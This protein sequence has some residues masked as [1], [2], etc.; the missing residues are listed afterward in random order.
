MPNGFETTVKL[1]TEVDYS[2]IEKINPN[3]VAR[4]LSKAYGPI[5]KKLFRDPFL[6]LSKEYTK[7]NLKFLDR[8]A[9]RSYSRDIQS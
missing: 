8:G 1:V 2:S 4:R 3:E 7:A 9:L 6:E 5:T